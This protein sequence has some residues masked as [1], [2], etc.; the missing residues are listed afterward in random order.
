MADVFKIVMRLGAL[1]LI[2]VILML[3][4]KNAGILVV[5]VGAGIGG[6]VIANFIKIFLSNINVILYNNIIVFKFKCYYFII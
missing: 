3:L 1:A 5:I 4:L 2:V 6:F